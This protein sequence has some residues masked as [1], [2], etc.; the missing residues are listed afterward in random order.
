MNTNPIRQGTSATTSTTSGEVLLF[1]GIK[2][3]SSSQ[4]PFVS[5]ITRQ[6]LSHADFQTRIKSIVETNVTEY[7][8]KKLTAES[9]IIGNPFDAI[10]LS[11]LMPDSVGRQDLQR[12][13]AF[14][15]IRD[16]SGEILF[17]DDLDN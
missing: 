16:L 7:L 15:N 4:S 1:P 12:I 2:D 11:K 5:R 6:I 9:A 17:A 13:K 10:Y 14:T 8:L 3:I